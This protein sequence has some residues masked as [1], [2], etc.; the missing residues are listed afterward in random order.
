[1]VL[2]LGAILLEVV[3]VVV[4]AVVEVSCDEKSKTR[5][6]KKGAREGWKGGVEGR[7]GREGSVDFSVSVTSLCKFSS[8]P[9]ASTS[10][11]KLCYDLLCV[12][13]LTHRVKLCGLPSLHK[14]QCLR[15]SEGHGPQL[16]EDSTWAGAFSSDLWDAACSGTSLIDIAKG[17][18]EMGNV[19][20]LDIMTS[21]GKNACFAP[22]IDPCIYHSD[23]RYNYGPAFADDPDG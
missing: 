20:K 22:I 14:D 10:N 11:R 23:F 17:R 21:G 13:H 4:V 2:L 16:E 7:D 9:S 3:V 8:Y 6:Q 18:Y 1:M 12:A 15:S 19:G 5:R